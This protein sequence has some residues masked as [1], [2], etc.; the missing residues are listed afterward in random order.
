MNNY[1]SE[2]LE[3]FGIV[4]RNNDRA[5]SLE[6]FTPEAIFE[7][8]RRH[9]IVVFRGY[10]T[11]P[12]QQLALFAQHLGEPLQWEFGAINELQFKPDTQNYIFTD[13][14]VPMHWDGAFAGKI[15]YIILFQCLIAPAKEDA[16]GTT[17][18]DTAKIVRRAA[19]SQMEKWRGVSITYETEKLVHYGGKITQPFLQSHPLTEETVI[20]YA[21]PVKDLNPVTLDIKGVSGQTSEAFIGDME[22]LLYDED[23]LY[24]HNWQ[25]GD[26]VLADN[27]TLLHGR[28]AFHN[29]HQRHIQ[30]INIL[31]RPAKGSFLR[32]LKNCFTIRRK[33][34]F[35]A[36][37]PIFLIPIFLSIAAPKDFLNPSFGLGLAAI[38]LLFNIGDMINCYADYEL[39]AIYK[40]H[41]SNAVYELGKRNV[42]LQIAGSGILAL[43]L[44]VWVS[45]LSRQLYLIPLTLCGIFIGLEY[46]IKPFKFKSGGVAQLVCLWGIIFFGPMLYVGIISNGFPAALELM[47]FALYGAHQMGIIML[48]TAEDYTED[49]TAGLKTI[50]VVL[51]LHRAMR[52]AWQL[53]F[54]SGIAL[55]VVFSVLFYQHRAPIWITL[56]VLVFTCGWLKIILEYRRIVRRIRTMNEEEATKELKKNGRKVPEWLKLGAY[57]SLVVVLALFSWKVSANQ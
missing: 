29:P 46:S 54:L 25:A 27:F 43:A 34:F 14:A 12:K 20:R 33:E 9:K 6:Q 10:E 3:P 35:V 2:T 18:C 24:T 53:V 42:L 49:K 37:L 41:L 23:F 1:T 51:G 7:L 56:S 21:E 30:R 8:L 32:F 19:A 15:P 40:S 47:V 26:I 22:K 28:Q 44:T 16:G 39:D 55:Q 5:N 31:P 45:V 50:I 38:F 11:L 52:F 4:I 48:N 17:F 36:E 13:H 57:A